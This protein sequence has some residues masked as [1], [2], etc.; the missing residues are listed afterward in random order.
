MVKM[1]EVKRL[2]EDGIRRKYFSESPK[3]IVGLFIEGILNPLKELDLK[4]ITADIPKLSFEDYS[5]NAV[6]ALAIIE[7]L[8]DI[9]DAISGI[10]RASKNYT[11]I[12][13]ANKPFSGLKN[14][15][16]RKNAQTF[17]NIPDSVQYFNKQSLEGGSSKVQI[18]NNAFLGLLRHQNFIGR[19]I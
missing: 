16:H 2:M 11:L 15:L 14:F 3:W 4:Y 12:T 7:H 13:M 17:T 9:N 1:D 18:K 8:S 6:I 10:E 19:G 5:Y